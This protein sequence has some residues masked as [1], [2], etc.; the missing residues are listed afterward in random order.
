MVAGGAHVFSLQIIC[1]TPC[2]GKILQDILHSLVNF[3]LVDVAG[4]MLPVVD[5]RNLNLCEETA[6]I[7][8]D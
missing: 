5:S 7:V 3:D 2:C 1:S 6:R 4:L 8:L